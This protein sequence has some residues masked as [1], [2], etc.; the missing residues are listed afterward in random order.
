MAARIYVRPPEQVPTIAELS[1]VLLNHH[2]ILAIVGDENSADRTC[3]VL[4][5]SAMPVTYWPTWM[6]I[7]RNT[8]FFDCGTTPAQRYALT[9]IAR[10]YQTWVFFVPDPA[11]QN[12]LDAKFRTLK[13]TA[14]ENVDVTDTIVEISRWI[15]DTIG[16]MP[17][18]ESSNVF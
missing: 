17:A 14:P 12:E 7:F 11:L 10:A 2:A 16:E 8:A 5:P 6:D 9:N 4:I 13:E 18:F 1:Y 15:N 3:N